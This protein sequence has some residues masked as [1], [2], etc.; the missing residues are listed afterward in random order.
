MKVL[1]TG[2]TGFLGRHVRAHVARVAPEVNV[3]SIGRDACDLVEGD[4]ATMLA[5]ALPEVVIHLAG[6]ISGAPESI[7]RDN[8]PGARR[9]FEAM[10]T[11]VQ[12][13]KLVLVSSTAVYGVGGT[14]EKPVDETFV[15]QPRGAYAEAKLA[16]EQLGQAYAQA[17]GHGVIVR[18]SNPIGPGMSTSLLCGTIAEQVLSIELGEHEPVLSLYD[19]TPVRDFLDVSD[20]ASAIWHLVQHGEAGEIY[21][22]AAGASMS[23]K[24]VVDIFISEA[25]AAKIEVR[26]DDSASR[27]SPIPKQ[28]VS[29]IRLQGTG[30]R[31]E[32]NVRQAIHRL[33]SEGR[34]ARRARISS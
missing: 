26:C 33:L 8:V 2:G 25:K 32:S 30:W 12:K 17:G 28:W 7:T 3:Q 31:I 13:P 4:V 34:D 18:L 1:S 15:P 6:R 9:L 29:N 10:A 16:V 22:V 24:E 14:Q 27:R 5:Q 20:C 21:N 11:L 23:V 19:T